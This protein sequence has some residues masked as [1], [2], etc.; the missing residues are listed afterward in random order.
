MPPSSARIAIRDV[1]C[2][3]QRVKLRWI[4]ALT[5]LLL[6]NLPAQSRI[7]TGKVA[8][9]Y[10]E[11]CASCHGA[12]LEGGLGGSLL[13]GPWQHGDG[14]AESITKI[15][16]QGATDV[17][18]PAYGDTLGADEIRAL[19][20]FILEERD[21]HAEK[22]PVPDPDAWTDDTVFTAGDVSFQAESVASSDTEL[23]AIDFLPGGQLIA[24]EK[25][26][27][28][29]LIE[30]GQL[31]PPIKG[32]PRVR[33][34][35]QGGLLDVGVH[36][37]YAEN[38]WIYLSFSEPTDA[39]PVTSMTTVVRGRIRDGAWVDEETIFRAKA[40][41]FM[42]TAHHYG[43][44]FVFH[45][46]Y[47]FFGIGDRGKQDMAQ[48]LTVPN[49]KI[50]R[51]HDD[52]RIPSDNPF[53]D[54]GD[55]YPSIWAYGNRNPQGLTLDRKTGRIWETEHGP[56]GGDELNLI[57]G[58]TNYGWPVV[59][60]GMNY[61]GTPITSQT[62]APGIQDP[63][64]YW[65]PSLGVC[66]TTFYDGDA[67]PGWKGNLLVSGLATRD[68]R[69]VVLDGEKVTSQE[70]LLKNLGRVRDVI[71]GPDGHPYAIINDAS[72]DRGQPGQIIRLVPE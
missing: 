46:G 2:H 37:D 69:R 50:H 71:T 38:G 12:K 52:G 35:G 44:R 4:L 58:G 28:L 56:R 25:S 68:L 70:I 11:H 62:T 15:T 47:L 3:L 32:T 34:D 64:T 42:T 22:P 33:A 29:R 59:T 13:A 57:Q 19:T 61:N 53:V 26:G 14:G 36:P 7:G 55:A 60:Y 31:A 51:V 30:D 8:E 65:L 45:D 54:D 27:N 5:P 72:G 17:G 18:M 49:G 23:W 39:D 9:V 16:T 24:T 67:F 20:I 41:D 6:T 43:S 66:G 1:R 48:D 21:L 63:T 10:R 40:D